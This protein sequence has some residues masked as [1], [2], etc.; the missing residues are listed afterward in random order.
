MVAKI[1]VKNY[2]PGGIKFQKQD[3]F[4]IFESTKLKQALQYMPR[5]RTILNDYSIVVEK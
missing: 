2:D 4:Y 1:D 5:A 3:E